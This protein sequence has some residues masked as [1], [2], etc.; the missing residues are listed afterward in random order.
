MSD[1]YDELAVLWQEYRYR[2]DEP[3][4]GGLLVAPEANDEHTHALLAELPTLPNDFGAIESAIAW[5]REHGAVLQHLPRMERLHHLLRRLD[6][7]LTDVGPVMISTAT[8]RLLLGERW[9]SMYRS[10]MLAETKREISETGWVRDIVPLSRIRVLPEQADR[11]LE[12]ERLHERMWS[13]LRKR[14]QQEG[15]LTSPELRIGLCVLGRHA[16]MQFDATGELDQT[17]RIYGFRAVEV[18]WDGGD[19]GSVEAELR[20]CVTWARETRINVLCFPELALDENG[21]KALRLE[22]ERDP[23]SLCLIVPGSFHERDEKAGKT[24]GWVNRARIWTVRVGENA[25]I[26]ELGA[27][28]KTEPFTMSPAHV[29]GAIRNHDPECGCVGYREHIDP[30]DQLTIVSTPI[31]RFGIAICKDFFRSRLMDRYAPAVDHLIV[32]SMNEAVTDWF[33]FSSEELAKRSIAASYYV[34]STQFIAENDATVDL[35]FF[36]FPDQTMVRNAVYYGQTPVPKP[37]RRAD[38]RAIC[39]DHRVSASVPI[40][41]TLLSS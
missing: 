24:I 23:G 3:E 35:A 41:R 40:P 20:A 36:C 2:L 38:A 31:G 15:S 27:F 9:W 8:G 25:E 39:A 4:Y 18:V 32:V 17:R 22:I 30:G 34:N 5:W 13:T 14:R 19:H 6:R 1:C 10:A 28:E 29:E 26:V 7:A 33:W 37:A 21:Q 11:W 12:S 16:K